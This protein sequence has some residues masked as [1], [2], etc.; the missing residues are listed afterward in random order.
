MDNQER[1]AG[2]VGPK[3]TVWPA[4]AG[5]VPPLADGFSTR[6][7]TAPGLGAALVPG[8][9]VVL[10]PGQEAAD[11]SRDWL[12]SCGK[13]QLAVYFAESLW[14]VPAGWTCWSGSTATSRASVLSGYVEAAAAIGSDPAGDA[15]SVAA[16]FVGWLAETSRPW[17]VVLDDLRDAAD[18]E[19]CGLTG[20]RAGS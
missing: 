1:T 14:Q 12:G 10:V 9:A 4:R 16:R 2:P 17:L 11:G 3:A 20:R 15:E 7:E 6:P 18:L 5:A 8:A 19:G 13:T